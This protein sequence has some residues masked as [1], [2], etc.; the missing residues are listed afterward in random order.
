MASTALPAKVI[1]ILNR[2]HIR[3]S[4]CPLVR[5][6]TTAHSI[7]AGRLAVFGI[8][9]PIHIGP[10]S[11]NLRSITKVE[12]V[13]FSGPLFSITAQEEVLQFEARSQ[14]ERNLWVSSIQQ[15]MQCPTGKVLRNPPPPPPR[16]AAAVS[17][18]VDPLKRT[19]EEP[20]EESDACA[21]PGMFDDWESVEITSTE[22]SDAEQY[23]ELDFDTYGF[24]IEPQVVQCS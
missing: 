5:L 18:L 22:P 16:P 9:M 10:I 19:D 21:V 2:P 1:G 8:P 12:Y 6:F 13:G 20:L 17:P 7:L 11:I 24:K 23:V 3:T 4:L 15:W 14:G